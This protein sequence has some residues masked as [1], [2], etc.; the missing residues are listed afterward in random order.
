MSRKTY[1]LVGAMYAI[2]G[3]GLCAGC[4]AQA[5]RG[6]GEKERERAKY[7]RNAGSRNFMACRAVV[8]GQMSNDIS[9]HQTA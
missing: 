7:E 3:G 8:I 5:A 4:T 1:R 2:Q 9:F 6:Y